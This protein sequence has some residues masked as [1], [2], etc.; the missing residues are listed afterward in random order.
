MTEK[1]YKIDDRPK[2]N[3]AGWINN[4]SDPFLLHLDSLFKIGSKREIDIHDLGLLPDTSRTN[5]VFNIILDNWKNEL[6]LPIEKRSLI[7]TLR[8]SLGISPIIL[9]YSLHGFNAATGFAGPMMLKQL[10]QHL[11]GENKLPESTLWIF[12]FILLFAPIFGVLCKEYGN[13]VLL[14]LGTKLRGALI[15]FVLRKSCNLT[16]ESRG[17]NSGTV[18]NIFVSDTEQL[19]LIPMFA[20]ASFF[21]PAQLAIGLALV[22]QEL[23][24][25]TFFSIAFLFAI[26]PIMGICG[27]G[28]G[29]YIKK[30][31]AVADDRIKLTKEIISGIRKIKYF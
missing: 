23:G 3:Y 19:T 16:S 28:F 18:D 9:G 29:F 26:I 5:H 6:K 27:A 2:I 11:S 17:L 14:R 1:V 21:A 30:K 4:I 22:Y 15:S 13:L 7:R 24:P 25:S 8:L 20:A 10:L 31:L 12:L